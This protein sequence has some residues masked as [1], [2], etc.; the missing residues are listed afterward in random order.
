VQRQHQN[1]QTI[2]FFNFICAWNSDCRIYFRI[3]LVFQLTVCCPHLYTTD[4]TDEV[5][6][7][8]NSDEAADQVDANSD[9][10]DLDDMRH[11]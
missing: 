7:Q 5:I 2:V 4:V 3:V 6:N 1:L 10:E 11:G 9:V 8:T